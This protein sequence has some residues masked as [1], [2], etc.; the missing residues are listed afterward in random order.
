[1]ES[2]PDVER[3]EEDRGDDHAHGV[4]PAQQRH[5]DG[6]EA[7]PARNV[8]QQKLM[9]AGNLDHAGEPREPAGNARHHDP[10]PADRHSRIAR[11]LL[12]GADDAGTE[13]DR[14]AQHQPVK[15][16]GRRDGDEDA[17]VQARRTQD[18][19]QLRGFGYGVGLGEE[20]IRLDERPGDEVVD[21]V[22]RDV[23][24]HDGGDDLRGAELRP[25]DTGD[26][27]PERAADE[28]GE[29]HRGQGDIGRPAMRVE[30]NPHRGERAH[31]DLTFGADIPE[32]RPERQGET[33]TRRATGVWP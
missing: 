17:G 8:L 21:H 7:Q 25:E 2:A 5:H 16:S 12:V 4:E 32:T 22:E 27:P 14:R 31:E 23:V 24:E 19:R 26:H 15:D 28:P 1:M 20:L 13:P 30:A 10:G 6:G 9:N 33:R 3:R 11:G 18:A 29:D